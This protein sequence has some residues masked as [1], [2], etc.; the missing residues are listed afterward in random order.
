MTTAGDHLVGGPRQG[1]VHVLHLGDAHAPH[2]EDDPHLIVS[3][4]A[5]LHHRGDHPVRPQMAQMMTKH[6]LVVLLHADA[7][8]VLRYLRFDLGSLKM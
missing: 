1:D 4:A 2:H 6:H 5:D 3:V 8:A 7:P